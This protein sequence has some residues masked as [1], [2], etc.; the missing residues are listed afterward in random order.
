MCGIFSLIN[1]AG[2]GDTTPVV[3]GTEI[4]NHRGPDDEGYLLWNGDTDLKLFSGQNTNQESSSYHNLPFIPNEYPWKVGLGHRR[5]SIIDLSPAG[6]QPMATQL[7]GLAVAY[8]GEIYNYREIKSEL[9]TQGVHFQT[10][11]DTEVLL[12]AWE[13]WGEYAPHHFNGMFA[14]VVLDTR[15][16]KLYAVRDRFG[17]KPLYYAI[18]DN[19]IVFAS[20]IKQIRSLP[21]FNSKLNETVAFE[22]LV[23]GSLDH[24][25]ETFDRQVCQLRGGEM[26][27]VDLTSLSQHEDQNTKD[28]LKL[29]VKRWYELQPKKWQ[30]RGKD[31]EGQFSTL[32]RDSVNL[33][34][35]ADVK[36]GSCLS[37]GLDSSA[38]VCQVAEILKQNQGKVGQ[39]TVTACF[40][41]EKYDEWPYAEQVIHRTKATSHRVWPTSHKL[42]EDLDRLL[43]HMDEPFGS[44]SQFS[45]WCVFEVAANV[46]LKVMLDGQ[47]S[48]EMLAG[49]GGND[50]PLYSG[51]LKKLKLGSLWE[52][53]HGFKKEMGYAPKGQLLQA[54]ARNYSFLQSIVTKPLRS[55]PS[56]VRQEA[57]EWKEKTSLV[58]RS[59]QEEMI[60]Q[61]TTTS[62]PA[63]LR[64][65]D[66]NSM[67]FGVESRV[68]FLDHR[69]VEFLL[70]L[71]EEFIYHLGIR[72]VILRSA[73]RSLVPSK[74]LDRRDKMGFVTPEEIWLK[75]EKRDWF[76]TALEEGYE[77]MPGWLNKSKIQNMIDL[78]LND[79]SVF[80]FTPWR[81][82][83]FT[84]WLKKLG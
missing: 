23:N 57:F 75:Q 78:V 52:N 28:S 40:N 76:K 18:L 32:F 30:G 84:R 37:G 14:F 81:I 26:A 29:Q 64:Y 47:G 58:P 54:A 56:W 79:K 60:L 16:R 19:Y 61:V 44:T 48:D 42:L 83:M 55:S 35:R 43:W 68:P 66:R 24:K 13:Q 20:E 51:L 59:L 72:K 17:I 3:D 5:L 77:I 65:E 46:G 69:L 82:L 36:V 73:L 71:P 15:N 74:V 27:L 22:Y 7:S 50:V 49:Y 31:V 1:L 25:S 4:V 39:E 70:G 11:T 21:A 41:L 62:L 34:L 8:N 45:Q 10:S 38:I 63:L 2:S 33:R 53:Y 6:H 80:S 12:K 67:A 9:Q